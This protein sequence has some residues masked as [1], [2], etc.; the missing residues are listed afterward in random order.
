MLKIRDNAT[1][2]TA[3]TH[4]GHSLSLSSQRG[5]KVLLWFYPKADTPG[6]TREGRGFRD[7]YGDFQK[8]GIV[9]LGVSFD[10]AAANAA[11]ASKN[12]FPFRLLSDTDRKIGLASGACRD[13]GAAYPMRINYLIDE[14]RK[15]AA[16]YPK[17]NPADHA[18]EVLADAASE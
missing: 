17:V 15:I 4:E 13:A 9:I 2:F 6:G 18:A 12:R 8:A 5:R 16:V 14:Q 1:E 7:H 3:N 10:D 11:F